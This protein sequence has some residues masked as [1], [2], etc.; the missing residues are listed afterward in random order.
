M[1]DSSVDVAVG[2]GYDVEGSINSLHRT[3]DPTPTPVSSSSRHMA[4]DENRPLLSRHARQIEERRKGERRERQRGTGVSIVERIQVP[5][6]SIYLLPSA[7][8]AGGVI[9]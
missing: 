1:A 9:P 7:H 4:S 6:V 5:F 3:W 2:D 8:S